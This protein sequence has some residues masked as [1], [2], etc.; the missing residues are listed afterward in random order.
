M[1]ALKTHQDYALSPHLETLLTQLQDGQRWLA[2][3]DAG[4]IKGLVT[5]IRKLH[6]PEK[7]IALYEGTFAENA[8]ELSPLLI[9]LNAD[10]YQASLEVSRLDDL[11]AGRP[12]LGLIQAQQSTYQWLQH[13]RSLLRIQMDGSEYLWRLADTQMMKATVRVLNPEQ[14]EILFGG[15]QSWWVVTDDGVIENMASSQKKTVTEPAQTLQMDA[16]QETALLTQIAPFMLASQLRA[17][18]L[19]F[20]NQLSHAE[21]SRFSVTCIEEARAEFLDE[22]AELLPWALSRWQEIC[23][24]ND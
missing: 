14:K 5:R 7:C 24:A 22:D 12:I 16:D 15:C 6:P 11:C 3:V 8:I 2:L 4:Q 19:R 9:E 18:D 23:N 10:P 21:Q 17:M 20:L 1:Q 13:L